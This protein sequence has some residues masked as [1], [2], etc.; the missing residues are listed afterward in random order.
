MGKVVSR[1]LDGKPYE[2]MVVRWMV[3]KRMNAYRKAVGEET[4][5]ARSKVEGQTS[6]LRTGR[7]ARHS[8]RE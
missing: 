5:T 6:A 3:P 7:A 2:G 8:G 1:M 4:K